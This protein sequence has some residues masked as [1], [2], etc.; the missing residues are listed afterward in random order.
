MLFVRNTSIKNL[1]MAWQILIYGFEVPVLITKSQLSS[2]DLS[3]SHQLLSFCRIS[4][5]TIQHKWHGNHHVLSLLSK[6]SIHQKTGSRKNTENKL[7]QT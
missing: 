7:K 4:C 6:Y 2:V 3:S 1:F 5:K